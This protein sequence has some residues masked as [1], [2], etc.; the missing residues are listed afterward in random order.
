MRG[1]ATFGPS[2]KLPVPFKSGAP[3]RVAPRRRHDGEYMGVPGTPE[4]QL[5][6]RVSLQYAVT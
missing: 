3:S 2:F 4:P 1:L 5:L 6:P